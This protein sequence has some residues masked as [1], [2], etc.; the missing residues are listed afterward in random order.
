ML[1]S[2]APLGAAAHSARRAR[3][4][5]A[6]CRSAGATRIRAALQE[7]RQRRSRKDDEE[8]GDG[9][10]L[11]G[12]KITLRV[13]DEP[14]QGSRERQRYYDDDY[15]DDRPPRRA[16]PPRQEE[17]PSGSPFDGLLNAFKGKEEK[18]FDSYAPPRSEERQGRRTASSRPAR[19]AYDDDFDDEPP[20]RNGNGAS[21][22]GGFLGGLA[23]LSKAPEAL[24]NMAEE[25]SFKRKEEEVRREPRRESSGSGSRERR[26]LVRRDDPEDDYYDE[27]PLA[28]EEKGRGPFSINRRTAIAACVCCGGAAVG[29]SAH[30]SACPSSPPWDP[31]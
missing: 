3:S 23:A 22:G 16:P 8:E 12:R 31:G 30:R 9:I 2:T 17:K 29:V 14:K 10:S 18:E 5:R 11:F 20:A 15:E 19:P 7:G 28:K 4:Q 24:A 13:E 25:L 21:N 1:L 26:R 27:R 6:Q